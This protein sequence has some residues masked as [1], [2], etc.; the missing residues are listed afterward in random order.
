MQIVN[1]FK[2]LTGSELLTHVSDADSIVDLNG[3][4]TSIIPRTLPFANQAEISTIDEATHV[5]VRTRFMDNE[6]LVKI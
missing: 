4:M 3:E 1:N 6:T 5:G 2:G